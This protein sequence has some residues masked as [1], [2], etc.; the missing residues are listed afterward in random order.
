M[1][2]N[3]RKR[4]KRRAAAVIRHIAKR[5]GGSAK[6]SRSRVAW[7]SGKRACSISAINSALARWRAARGKKRRSGIAPSLLL[8]CRGKRVARIA[9]A[10]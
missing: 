4:I 8:A 10:K 5:H 1:A 6:I 9:S 2:K 3:R 7:Q